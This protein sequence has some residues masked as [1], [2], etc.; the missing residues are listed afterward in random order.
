MSKTLT[1]MLGLA[2]A[3][4]V[5]FGAPALQFAAV[6]AALGWVAYEDNKRS[7]EARK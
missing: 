4:A 5:F 7:K 6:G 1:I 2:I 3:G